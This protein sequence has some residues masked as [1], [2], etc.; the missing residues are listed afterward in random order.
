MKIIVLMGSMLIGQQVFAEVCVDKNS[1]TVDGDKHY[2]YPE[3][4]FDQVKLITDKKSNKQVQYISNPTSVKLDLVGFEKWKGG[5]QVAKDIEEARQRFERVL[6]TVDFKNEILSHKYKNE[7]Q[8]KKNNGKSNSD[9]YQIIL[10]GADKYDRTVDR[11]ISM[12]LCPYYSSKKV[13]G[14]TYR[15]RKEVWVNFK[16][17]R[18]HYN[19]FNI[20]SIVGNLLHEWIH[21]TGFGHASKSNNTRKHTVPYAI[22]YKA[23]DIA[24]QL[25]R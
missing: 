17:Y 1:F 2:V 9:I 18:D 14:Y 11:E 4:V 15:S 22:G 16:Y 6:A 8:Y 12:I 20:S 13:L 19:K 24:S 3:A 7:F 21:N 25:H 10:D 5:I 23:R